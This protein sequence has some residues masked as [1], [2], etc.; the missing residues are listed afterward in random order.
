MLCRLVN[1]RH[2]LHED[3]ARWLFQQLMLAV[4]YMHRLAS[5]CCCHLLVYSDLSLSVQ[6]QQL[7][8]R[9]NAVGLTLPNL[10]RMGVVNRDIKLENI[11]LKAYETH[12]ILK[13]CD[14]GYSI[15]ENHSLPKT[16]LGT[17]GYTGMANLKAKAIRKPITLNAVCQQGP[18]PKPWQY[19]NPSL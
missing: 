7:S 17:P 4:D 3:D 18:N 5:R 13:I 11:L 9:S 14:F 19:V 16:A 12:P 6:G 10:C 15:N 8:L 1:D 2:G